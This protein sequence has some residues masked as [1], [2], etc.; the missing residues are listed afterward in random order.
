MDYGAD[1]RHS[2]PRTLGK[3]AWRLGWS[4]FGVAE[5]A[6]ARESFDVKRRRPVRSGAIQSR[7]HHINISMRI[8]AMRN[9]A[10]KLMILVAG[11]GGAVAAAAQGVVAQLQD[12]GEISAADVGSGKLHFRIE[13]Q[14]SDSIHILSWGTPL[15]DEMTANLFRVEQNG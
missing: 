6:A 5:S 9:F 4:C 13:N 3:C 15:G 14:G 7:A 1:Q 2:L 8:K 10:V 11:F 12:A